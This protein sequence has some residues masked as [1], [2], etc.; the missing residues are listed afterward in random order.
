M[1]SIEI[2]SQN[3]PAHVWRN[4]I[5]DLD[6]GSDIAKYV[7][8]ERY[9]W[10]GGYELYAITDDGGCLCHDCCRTEFELILWS[11]KNDCSDGWKVV[12][13][14]STAMD[15]GLV[16]CDHCNKGINIQC[17]DCFEY[18]DTVEELYA[19]MDDCHV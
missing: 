12:A 15:E 19:H 7:A 8:R 3:N 9:A 2:Y 17:E 16:Q 10:P 6:S 13:M 14:Q 18:Y 1:N 11:V 4:Y 5:Y